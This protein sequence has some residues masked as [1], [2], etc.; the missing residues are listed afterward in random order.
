MLNKEDSRKNLETC[1][2]ELAEQLTELRI[3][4]NL[5][6][7]DVEE[8]TGVSATHLRRLENGERN[9]FGALHQLARFYEK[10]IRIMLY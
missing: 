9:D 10:K 7:E 4:K 3:S 2:R 5:S 8:S 1:R 6:I